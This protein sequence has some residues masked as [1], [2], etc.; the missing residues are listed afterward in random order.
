VWQARHWLWWSKTHIL[1]AL[2]MCLWAT[3]Y[4]C[5][6]LSFPIYVKNELDN[7]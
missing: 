1:S 5:V 2:A 7:L 3:H 4:V 6:C